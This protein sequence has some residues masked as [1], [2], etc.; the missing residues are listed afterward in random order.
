MKKSFGCEFVHNSIRPASTEYNPQFEHRK[1]S[2]DPSPEKED[3]EEFWNYWQEHEQKL[4]NR[5]L[6]LSGGNRHDAEDALSDCMIKAYNYASNATNKIKNKKAWLMQ[7][8]HNHFIDLYRKRKSVQFADESSNTLVETS[9]TLAL[10]PNQE[11]HMVHQEKLVQVLKSADELPKKLKQTFY[12]H[13]IQDLSYKS[14]AN[15]GG[16]TV[17]N[18]RKRVQLVRERLRKKLETG[19]GS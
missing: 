2:P 9:D 13:F 16:I 7:V 11:C 1:A 6:Y 15:Q 14:M 17:P 10:A 19:N 5:C 12:M 4:F 18:A 8:I 3:F